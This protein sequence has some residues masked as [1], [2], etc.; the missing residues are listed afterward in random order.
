MDLFINAFNTILC[1]PLLNA[2]ILLYEYLPGHSFG[3]AIIVLTILIKL[4]FYPLGAKGIQS[5]KALSQLQPK[6]KEVK[7]KFKNDKE[8][9]ARAMMELYKQEKINPVSGCLPLLIQLPILFALFRVFWRGF[10]EE[11]LGFLYSFVPYPG[12]INTVFLGMID[13]AKGCTEKITE[14]GVEYSVYLWPTIILVFLVGIIQFI[15]T[16]MATPHRR[17][18]EGKGQPDFSQMM[19]KQMLYFFP[20]VTVFI[21]WRLPAAVALYWMTTTLFTI[22]Q[23]YLI[24]KK[25]PS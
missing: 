10:G 17:A 13:L 11:Q 24:F 2:L 22:G 16:K 15:Q 1:Q 19:Q 14:N 18:G 25:R 4:I 5:Q 6:I 8:K 21:L 12:Q 3:I 23:Q 9:Q 7:E 20:I